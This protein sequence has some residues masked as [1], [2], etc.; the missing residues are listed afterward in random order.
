MN[1]WGWMLLGVGVAAGLWGALMGNR[2]GTGLDMADDRL[3]NTVRR[4]NLE[5]ERNKQDADAEAARRDASRERI[6]ALL[7]PRQD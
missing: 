3:K 2:R 4:L 6:D 5:A 7:A 1:W